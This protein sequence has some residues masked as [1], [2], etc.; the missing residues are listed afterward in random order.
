VLDADSPYD[1]ICRRATVTHVF[2]RGKL[3]VETKP[4]E[5]KWVEGVDG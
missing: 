4:A 5:V 2:S 1:A 3:L